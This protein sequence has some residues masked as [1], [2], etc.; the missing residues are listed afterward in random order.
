M[1]NPPLNESTVR[2]KLCLVFVRQFWNKNTVIMVLVNSKKCCL[3]SLLDK[4]QMLLSAHSAEDHTIQAVA[5]SAQ[6]HITLHRPWHN[7]LRDSTL[8][9]LQKEGLHRKQPKRATG[10]LSGLATLF[11]CKDTGLGDGE[12][13]HQLL[14]RP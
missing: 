3:C 1:L 11:G 4:P 10:G 8:R 5:H 14:N 9:P 12:F 7:H 6:D 13:P 2:V